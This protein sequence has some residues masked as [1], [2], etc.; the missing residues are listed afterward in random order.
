[1]KRYIAKVLLKTCLKGKPNGHKDRE[2]VVIQPGEE[3]PAKVV[4][5]I[6]P[7]LLAEGLVEV[8]E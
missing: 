4:E 7:W 3:V 5:K 8:V 1:M 6:S 2:E